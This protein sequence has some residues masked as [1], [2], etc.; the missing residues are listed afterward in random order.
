MKGVI[1]GEILRVTDGV[2]LAKLLILVEG[3][4]LDVALKITDSIRLVESEMDGVIFGLTDGVWLGELLM[5]VEGVMLKLTDGVQ[6][7]EILIL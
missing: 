7:G 2:W 1:D 6:L 5:L 3:V 4:M